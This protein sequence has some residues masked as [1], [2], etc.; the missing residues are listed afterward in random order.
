MKEMRNMNTMPRE[1]ISHE[2]DHSTSKKHHHHTHAHSSAHGGGHHLLQVED[3]C[4]SFSMYEQ[5]DSA[6]FGDYLRSE[7]HE[8]RVIDGL[9]ISVHEGEIV[10]VVGASGSGKTLLADSILGLYEPNSLVSGCIWFDGQRQDAA[11]LRRLRGREIAFVPQSVKALDP[12]MNVGRQVRGF[13]PLEGMSHRDRVQRQEELF[14]RYGLSA[15]VAKKYPHELSGGMA[16]RVLL[17]CALMTSPKLLIADE[18]TPG[19]DLDLAVTAMEDFRTLADNGVG[20]MLI[21]HDIDLA[22]RVADRLAI[23]KD[24][25][26]IEETSVAAFKEG[27]L[28]T[29]FSLQLRNALPEFGFTC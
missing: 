13:V 6:R 23:F 28:E 14:E 29:A 22:L 9:N 12:L 17:C 16:R 3:L 11:S 4:V 21:T 24:G 20:V 25:S 8:V 19:L 7:K 10:A 1:M 18:P 26:V 2:Q 5:N 27:A 15:D